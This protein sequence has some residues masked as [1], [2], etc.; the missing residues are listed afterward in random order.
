[1]KLE[2][3]KPVI[4]ESSGYFSLSDGTY[5]SSV[6]Q[7]VA[8]VP[9]N[10]TMAF[11][12]SVQGQHRDDWVSDPITDNKLDGFNDWAARVQLLIKSSDTFSALLNAH[13][14]NLNG[15]STLFRANIIQ[16][17]SNTLVPG[18]QPD[19]IYTDG[20]NASQLTTVGAN[21]HLTWQLPNMTLQSITGYES[22]TRYFSLGDI[23]G[24]C[25][26][27]FP[28][29]PLSE[30]NPACAKVV[31]PSSGPAGPGTIP[32][33]VETSA[34]LKN[35]LQLTQEFRVI[36][37]SAG[38]VTGQ[39]GAFFFYEDITS[40]DDDYC[41]PGEC[42]SPSVPLFTL[43]DTTVNHQRNDAEAVFGSLDY[44]A[45]EAL[46]TTAGIRFTADHKSFN[47]YYIDYVPPTNNEPSAP[48]AASRDANNVSWD[49]SAVYKLTP[50]ANLYARIATGFRAPSFGEPTPGLGI[51]VA[52]SETNISYETG[53]KAEMFEHKARLAFDVYYFHVNDQ[54]L[55]IVG[56]GSSDVTELISAKD[57]IGYGSEL[58]FE[59]HPVS[60][61][62]FNFS[63][64]Y[65]FTK[66][67]DPSLS[68]AVG[69]AVPPGDI[70]NP[71]TTVPG[72]FGPIYYANINGNPL[73]EA[74]KWVGDA[75]LRYDFPL[76]TGGKLY[77]TAD[78]SYRTT[79]NIELY[80][81]KEFEVPPLAQTGLHLGYNWHDGRYD[82]AVFCRNCTNQI[83]NIYD[84][85]FDNLTGVINDPRIVGAQFRMKF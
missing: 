52:P 22:V 67:E 61:L 20:P 26:F 30:S 58:E 24:G 54:Q 14:R 43:Q 37:K 31:P 65:N 47:A 8:N 63:G 85:D 55:T 76:P 17:G 75:S 38:P 74:P 23:D 35:H 2:S 83:R 62:T 48:L 9:I 18:F 12:A 80:L 32:F 49:L 13:V 19:Q 28:D 72:E 16:P 33:S 79:M 27:S 64:S 82:V 36:S 10:D 66:I 73:P 57:T 21:A 40:A 4:G 25:G 29:P 44:K 7:G 78:L 41:G 60:N 45:S 5:N 56:G 11:R 50:D 6:L 3:A 53:F 39:A 46:T 1:V 77:A 71:T 70:L 59:V 84:I 34:S 15:T 42:Y 68:V 51:Q 81:A 69:G